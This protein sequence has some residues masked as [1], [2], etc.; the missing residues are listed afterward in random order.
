MSL[1]ETTLIVDNFTT[2]SPVVAKKN[3][4][5]EEIGALLKEQNIRHLPIVDESHKPVG[6]ISDRDIKTVANFSDLKTL[7]AEDLMSYEPF[8]V[9]AEAPLE[10]VVLQMS[11]SKIGSAIVLYPEDD[12][13]GIFTSTDALNALVEVSRELYGEIVPKYGAKMDV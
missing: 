13:I 4:S 11:Q 5:I 7:K 8:T 1:K 3:T 10:D 12:S 6:V 9:H 2:P